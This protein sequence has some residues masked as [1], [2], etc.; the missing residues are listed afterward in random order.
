MLC[1]YCR[2][3]LTNDT[4]E[5]HVIPQALGGR[6]RA[7]TICC[8]DCNNALSPLENELCSSFR[9]I[10]AALAA[11]DSQRRPITARIAI[12]DKTFDYTFGLGHERLPSP[13]KKGKKLV[14]PLPGDPREQA[15]TIATHLWQ[16]GLQT[17]ALD[18][19]AVGI[20]PD[21]VFNIRPHPPER[22]M[23]ESR[24][25]TGTTAHMRV[26]VKIALEYLAHVR[27]DDARRWDLL[28]RARRYA[29]YG[30]DDGEL[31][32]RFD[33]ATAGL[34]STEELPALAHAIEVWTHGRNLHYRA[35]FFGGLRI[36][37]SLSTQWIGP[38]FSLG[39][40]FNPQDPGVDKITKC[41]E[42]DGPALRLYHP[43]LKG[44][45]FEGFAK[46]FME[47]TLEIS[48]RVIAKPWTAPPAP[49]LKNLRPLIEK[50]FARLRE[51]AERVAA[52]KLQGR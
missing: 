9:E 11:R 24:L 44:E 4:R 31:P 16:R 30:E 47:K 41:M 52:K 49:L 3:E 22:Q 5:A 25:E 18:D 32:A 39:H 34:F 1:I 6:L 13:V 8:S 7:K 10:S 20:E 29:R 23:M 38:A 48:Q 36:T 45:A 2:A 40:A 33:S 14:F 26:V 43:G 37:G 15:K 50:E 42:T 28:R 19:G 35:T 51:R 21:Q 46:L 27:P 17:T 12:E